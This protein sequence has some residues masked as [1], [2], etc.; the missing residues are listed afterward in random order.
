M[1]ILELIA[2]DVVE[3]EMDE[4]ADHVQEALDAGMAPKEVLDNGMLK[5]MNIVGEQFK[6][7]EMFVPEVLMSAKTMD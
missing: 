3:G 2:N 7:G 5:G 6:E 4:I 1:D